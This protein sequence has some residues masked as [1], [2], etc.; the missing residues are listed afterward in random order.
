MV[1]LFSGVGFRASARCGYG[2]MPRIALT[3]GAYQAHSVIASAQRSLNLFAEPMP[4]STGESAQWAHYPTPGLTL[5]GTLPQGPVRA[6]RQCTTGAVYAVGGSGVY[7]VNTTDWTSTHLGDITALRPY[8]VSMCDNGNTM[9]IVDGTAGGWTIDLASNAFSSISDPAFPGA[10]KVDFLD[11]YFLLNKPGT[12]QFYWSGSEEVSWD[13]LDFANKESFSDLLITLAVAK[14]E[15]WLIGER[16]TEVWANVG[17]SSSTDITFSQFQQLQSVFVDHGCR[18]KYSVATYDNAAYWLAYDR[19]G[20]GFVISGAGY[21]TRRISTFA[22]EAEFT[23]YARIDDAIGFTYSLGGHVFYVLTFPTADKTWVHDITTQ[24]WHEWLWI[25]NDG[26]EHRHRANCCYPCNGILVAGDH[27]NG[28]LYMLNPG[29]YTDVGQPIKRIRSY[30]HIVNEMDRIFYRQ[31]IADVEC[32]NDVVTCA[33]QGSGGAPSVST[34]QL[35]QLNSSAVGAW[36]TGLVA[37]SAM[38]FPAGNFGYLLYSQWICGRYVAPT[39]SAIAVNFTA[40]A[41]SVVFEPV[42]GVV[43][44]GNPA[45]FTGS[46]AGYGGNVLTHMLLSVDAQRQII[47]LYFN[48]Q[49][50][51]VSGA[52]TGGLGSNWFN[53]GTG[54]AIWGWAGES[55]SIVNPPGVSDIW[56]AAPATFFDL[57]NIANR[58]KFINPDLTPAALGSDGSLPLGTRPQIYS[59]VLAGGAPSD[60]LTNR[61]LGI[62]FVTGSGTTLTLQTAGTCIPPPPPGT[63]PG[64]VPL[65]PP[66]RRIYLE[67]SDDRGRSFGNPVAQ[68]LGEVGQYVNVAQ[69]QRLGYGRD[70]VFRLSTSAP[71]G[72]GLLGAYIEVD[73]RAKS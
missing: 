42:H 2:V 27:D 4:Q 52:W 7:L 16:T 12:P 29:C 47:Q 32:G 54:S 57:T 40:G 44:L 3:G 6:I 31:F 10:D 8:P 46:F 69:W 63:P 30:P 66:S 67:W 15:I 14:R 34:G 56:C 60:L 48:D 55:A 11:T 36:G 17:A 9:L 1:G 23:K 59:A 50:V 13:S 41:A 25:D 24:Q 38:A 20:Q 49:P 18:A 37:A 65:A 68:D 28:N 62:G 22:I 26:H 70:R 51:I 19:A 35:T 39:A 21:Q 64:Q 45:F 71:I 5:L 33:G 53:V 61:G 72:F 43:Q 58:R 73:S